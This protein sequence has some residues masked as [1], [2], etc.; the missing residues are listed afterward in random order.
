MLA[1]AAG[2]L[3]VKPDEVP[4][5]I[6]RLLGELKAARQEVA[7]AQAQAAAG[8]AGE[9]AA[10]A[11]DGV[12][13]ARRDLPSDDLR[14]PRDRNARRARLRC[15]RPGRH[16]APRRREGRRSRSRVTS[17]LVARACRPRRSPRPAARLLGGG[18]GKN[19]EIAVGGGKNLDAVDAALD[20]VRAEA[21]AAL[22]GLA[23]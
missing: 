23:G 15:G 11:V 7:A 1:A 5:R 18:T 6:E 3:Q 2:A 9:L 13:V 19:P 10:G 12:V 22:R 20:A 8:E 14:R 16:R 21:A 17:D 4:D